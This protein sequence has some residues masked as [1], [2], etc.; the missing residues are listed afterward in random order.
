MKMR[1]K[2]KINVLL[3]F[4]LFSMCKSFVFLQIKTLQPTYFLFFFV[5]L[6]VSR[7]DLPNWLL[8]LQVL[9]HKIAV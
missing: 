5:I 1:K 3:L 8:L 9:Q 7:P 2:K 6:V 4:F